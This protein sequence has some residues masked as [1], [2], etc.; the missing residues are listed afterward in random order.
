[1]GCTETFSCTDMQNGKECPEN[2]ARRPLCACKQ[3]FF[4]DDTTKLC[5]E[6]CAVRDQCAEVSEE[7]FSEV[8]SDVASIM[9]MTFEKCGRNTPKGPSP[10][11]RVEKYSKQCLEMITEILPDEILDTQPDILPDHV[12]PLSLYQSEKDKF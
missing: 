2:E 3:G 6:D 4:F 12:Q 10:A 9:D 7:D 8:C 1:M 5:T 11:V